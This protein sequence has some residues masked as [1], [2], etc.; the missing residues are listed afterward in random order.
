[1]RALPMPRRWRSG[2]T[3]TGP[4]PNQPVCF[5]STATGEKATWPTASLPMAATR[6]AARAPAWR[7]ASMI[8]PSAPELCPLSLKAAS[9][10]RRMASASSARSARISMSMA[11]LAR[12]QSHVQEELHPHRGYDQNAEGKRRAAPAH[13]VGADVD[14]G[15]DE[16]A[17]HE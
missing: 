9:V 14:G 13:L 15:V 3:D 1:I 2:L 16:A 11:C 5:P 6:D 7:S 8:A 17:C 10:T 12:T 4:R